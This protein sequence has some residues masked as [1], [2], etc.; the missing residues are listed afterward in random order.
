M[1]EDYNVAINPEEIDRGYES[2][3]G[4]LKKAKNK[5]IKKKKPMFIE[6]DE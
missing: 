6:R 3:E 4:P 1:Q 5:K 2:D